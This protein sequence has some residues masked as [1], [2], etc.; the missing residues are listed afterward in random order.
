MKCICDA[1]ALRVYSTMACEAIEV[2][3]RIA[4]EEKSR[5]LDNAERHSKR[6]AVE[7]AE[8]RNHVRA[9]EPTNRSN[10]PNG[11]IQ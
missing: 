8:C 5:I 2:L 9:T 3:A 10:N 11:G 7:R 4:P 1:S 6:I